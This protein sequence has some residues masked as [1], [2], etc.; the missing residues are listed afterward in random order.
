MAAGKPTII[1]SDY[2]VK[3]SVLMPGEEGVIELTLKNTALSS[4]VTTVSG[5]DSGDSE[6][7]TTNFNPTIESL[8]LHPDGV[9]VIGGNNQFIGDI[10]PGQE[11][12]VSFYI[13]APSKKGIYFPEVWAGVKGGEN[14]RYSIPVN[15]GMQLEFNKG[16]HLKLRTNAVAVKPGESVNTLVIITNEGQSEA[17]DIIV[18]FGSVDGIIAPA[19]ISS[20][21]I[22]SLSPGESLELPVKLITERRDLSKIVSLPVEIS[23]L[24]IDGDRISIDDSINLLLRGE[25]EISIDS[26]DNSVVPEGEPF[27]LI[28]RIE[29]SGTSTARSLNA[30]IAGLNGE[31]K[32]AYVGKIKAGNDAPAVFNFNGM[33]PGLYKGSLKISWIDEWGEKNVTDNIEVNVKESDDGWIVFLILFVAGAG[34]YAVYYYRIKKRQT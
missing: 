32:I 4:T 2:K 24:K 18:D 5:K 17:D 11:V 8:L 26:V 22:D 12:N 3:P 20:Y 10:G 7:F 27:D 19:S 31:T 14:L 9:T 21:Y 28:V 6:T 29:N 16:A 34:L 13:Q 30:K 1:V 25:P 15:V 23:Y 33:N